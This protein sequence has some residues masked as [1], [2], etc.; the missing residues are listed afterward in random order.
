MALVGMGIRGVY[1]GTNLTDGALIP[2]LLGGIATELLMPS[3][4]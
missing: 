3:V 2:G 4:Q 1:Y